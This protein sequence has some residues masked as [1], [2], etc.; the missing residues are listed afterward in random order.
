M[1][2]IDTHAHLYL[3][4]FDADNKEMLDRAWRNGVEKIFLPAIDSETHDRL[5]ALA[6]QPRTEHQP[7]I[8]PMM[9]LHPCSVKENYKDELAKAL[10]YLDNGTQY[11]AVG[12]IGLDFHWDVSFKAPN[13]LKPL[14]YADTVGYTAE[15]C[16]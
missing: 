9:G 14:R 4:D 11:Y 1:T 8:Y 6:D 3:S 12:E 15:A 7:T 5:L 16:P 2:L 13:S 10:R